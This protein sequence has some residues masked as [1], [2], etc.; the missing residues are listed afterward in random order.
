M[1]KDLKKFSALVFPIGLVF[2]LLGVLVEEETGCFYS[3]FGSGLLAVGIAKLVQYRRLAKDPE[4]LADYE[5]SLKDER[6][7]YVA[8]KA[9]SMTFFVT[10]YLELAAGLAA[11]YFLPDPLVG[12]ILC[13]A[14]SAQCLVFVLIYWYYNKKY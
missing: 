3:G 6:T 7:V 11:L 1:C 5:A 9:R 14:A 2:I 8:N 12:K 10:V 13:F 4:K